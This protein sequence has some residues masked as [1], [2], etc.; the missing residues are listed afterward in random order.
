M[1]TAMKEGRELRLFT[2]EFRNP[3][4]AEAAVQGIFIALEK[5]KGIIHLGG[6]ERVSRYEFGLLLRDVLGLHEA[7]LIQLRQRDIVMAAPRAADV[8]LDSSKA[9]ALGFSPLPLN[10]ELQKIRDML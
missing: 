9:Y 3:L 2:D 1:I 5:V 8:T 4:S 6:V 7:K 10:D